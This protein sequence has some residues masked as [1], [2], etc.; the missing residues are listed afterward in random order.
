MKMLNKLAASSAGW[1]RLRPAPNLLRTCAFLGSP[2]RATVY[3][4]IQ[5]KQTYCRDSLLS[6]SLSLSLSLLLLLLLL[7]L[8]AAPPLQGAG[9]QSGALAQGSFEWGP[10]SPESATAHST[11]STHA[12]AVQN[13]A[14]HRPLPPVGCETTVGLAPRLLP[15]GFHLEMRLP[16]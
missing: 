4:V 6:L 9:E 12:V 14:C 16:S 5:T 1:G 11:Y 10:T 3:R 13:M 2:K 7:L 8:R 15:R